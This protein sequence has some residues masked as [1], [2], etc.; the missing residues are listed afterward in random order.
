LII[1][2]TN[3]QLQEV[4][5]KGL[6]TKVIS[7][8]VAAAS[9]E[10][11][12]TLEGT[13]QA[14]IPPLDEA[15]TAALRKP[16]VRIAE[17]NVENHQIAEVFTR[18]NLRPTFSVFAQINNYT[19]APGMNEMLGQIW[20][21]AYPEYAVGFSLT[22][23]VKNRAAQA[24]D[25]RAR[26]E[27]Q[28]AQVALDQ[29]RANSVMQVRTAVTNLTSIRSQVEA[30][31]K[32]VAA[33]QETAEAEQEKWTIGVSS[34]DKVYQTQVDL[35]RA[36]L[37]SINSQVNYAKA[38]VAAQ[39]AAGG[40]LQIHGIAFEDALKGSLWKGPALR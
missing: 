5:L 8:E 33:S 32:A 13:M 19:L 39:L 26:L 36:Q 4:R 10:P 35:V 22:F 3:V 23:S 28:Q 16:S 25:V 29:T 17:L 27:L 30:A 1:A 24:D 6:I 21:Y 40:F 14:S 9:F 7:S 18:S 15:L 34:M 31:Q 2:Q 37:V 11:V 38:L 12:D 20:R